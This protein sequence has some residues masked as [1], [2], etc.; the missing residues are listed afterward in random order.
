MVL[1]LT[2]FLL[3]FYGFSDSTPCLN[4]S[5]SWPFSREAFAK[6]RVRREIRGHL[7]KIVII[8][9]FDD[10]TSMGPTGSLLCYLLANLSRKI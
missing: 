10:R 3:V 2:I 9:L 4:A 8:L 6:G 1:Y 7:L 5:R